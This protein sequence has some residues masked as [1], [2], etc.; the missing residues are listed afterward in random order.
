VNDELKDQRHCLCVD[1]SAQTVDM[2]SLARGRRTAA[3]R[4]FTRRQLRRRLGGRSIDPA[5]PEHGRLTRRD[6]DAVAERA[7]RGFD[8]LVG[9]AALDDIERRGNRL[10]VRLAVLTVAL[11]RALLDVGVPRSHAYDLVADAGWGLYEIGARPLV[12]AARFRSRDQ[13]Q[14]VSTAIRWLLRFPFSAPGRP[15]YEVE[16]CEA[17][18]AIYTNWTWCPPQAFVRR[19]V[20]ED[21]DRGDLE[22]F[23]RSWCAYDWAFNDRLASGTGDYSRPHTMSYGDTH[24]DMRWSTPVADP[25][26]RVIS[27]I[28][29]RPI[30]RL[31]ALRPRPTSA[32]AKRPAIPRASS[33][34]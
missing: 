4:W 28:S 33:T 18:D 10:N 31:E 12:A 1:L 27:R 2:G 19:L 15:G 29:G 9:F 23:R 34:A 13:Q 26:A 16:V 17:D 30:T 7:F 32:R 5:A 6:I 22:A 24:C 14:R 3:V 25:T 21:E 11:Y 20:A 8:D